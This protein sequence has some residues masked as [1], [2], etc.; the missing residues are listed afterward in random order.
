MKADAERR[1][2]CGIGNRIDRRV[3]VVP[4]DSGDVSCHQAK[5]DTPTNVPSPPQS[6]MMTVGI[7]RGSEENSERQ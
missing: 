5:E 3:V 1:R 4:S 7:G 6:T 2:F